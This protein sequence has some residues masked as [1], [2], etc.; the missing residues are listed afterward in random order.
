M[1]GQDSQTVIFKGTAGGGL[2]LKI[3]TVGPNASEFELGPRNLSFRLVFQI[4]LKQE[5]STSL[6]G[7]NC[8]ELHFYTR[9][10]WGTI[11]LGHLALGQQ[12]R[13]YQRGLPRDFRLM[14]WKTVGSGQGLLS[15]PS[16]LKSKQRV[17]PFPKHP[18]ISQVWSPFILWSSGKH[19]CMGEYK[20]IQMWI[21]ETEGGREEPN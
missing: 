14:K 19:I 16:A 11:K 21:I 13:K 9:G 2:L 4:I 8:C 3:H 10:N 12:M 17:S 7:K 20:Q 15:G 6:W 1:W 18:G 5:T